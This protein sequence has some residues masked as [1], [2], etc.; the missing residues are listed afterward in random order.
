MLINVPISQIDDNPFQRRQDYGDVAGLSADIQ[1]RGLR[2][3]EEREQ[4]ILAE[5]AAA[6]AVAQEASAP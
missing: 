5:Y 2:A 1:A 4:K 6:E 3:V